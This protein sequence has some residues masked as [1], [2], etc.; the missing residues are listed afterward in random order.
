MKFKGKLAE[1]DGASLSIAQIYRKVEGEEKGLA[2]A[3]PVWDGV[4]LEQGISL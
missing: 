1:M 4:I 3:L 2:D